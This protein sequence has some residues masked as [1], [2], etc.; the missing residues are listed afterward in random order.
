MSALDKLNEKKAVL[1]ELVARC[2]VAI[3]ELQPE[4]ASKKPKKTK[5]IKE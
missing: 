1:L 3:Q 5:E 4:E 2:D